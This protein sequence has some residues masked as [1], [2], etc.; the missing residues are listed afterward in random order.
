MNK[1]LYWVVSLL[2]ALS[3]I[4]A[5]CQTT[6]TQAPAA[7]EPAAATEAPAAGRTGCGYRSP[8]CRY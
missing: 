5:A 1:R 2:I 6:P 7:E 3:M 4:L 8:R